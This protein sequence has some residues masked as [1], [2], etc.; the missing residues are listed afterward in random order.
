MN[1]MTASTETMSAFAHERPPSAVR[2]LM[3]REHSVLRERIAAT[4]ALA[5]EA[6]RDSAVVHRFRAEALRLVAQIEWHLEDEERFV[7]PLLME[8]DA[9]GPERAH[10]MLEKHEAQRPGLAKIEALALDGSAADLTDAVQA[11]GQ[12]LLDVMKGEDAELL[13]ES[14]LRDDIVVVDQSDG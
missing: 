14:V 11:F 9:W 2:R 1:R 8:S 5:A 12:G 13:C 4:R 10:R 6:A 3:L 7:L